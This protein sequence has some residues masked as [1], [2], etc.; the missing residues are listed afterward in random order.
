MKKDAILSCFALIITVA[1]AGCSDGDPPVGESLQPVSTPLAYPPGPYGT[2]KGS[3]VAH[4]KLNGFQNAQIDHSATQPI[5]L[6]DFY[7]PHADDPGYAPANAAQD[8]RLFPPGSSYGGGTP[9][10]KALSITISSLWCGA[11]KN[12]AKTVLPAKYLKYKPLGGEFLVQLDDGPSQGHSA[13]QQ[14]LL[15]WT[16][17]FHVNYPATIDPG[18]QLDALFVA[19]VYP[20]NIIINTRTMKIVQS[21]PGVPEQSYWTK[22]EATLA[23]P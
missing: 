12:E 5:Q 20:A 18:R 3:I 22:F 2:T 4:Y 13:G 19:D 8:D 21:V 1:A 9:K 10:P 16:T 17:Q 15:T 6:A 11:C 7:N 23:G 14:D